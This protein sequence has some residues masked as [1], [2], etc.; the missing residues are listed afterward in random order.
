MC[1]NVDSLCPVC[2]HRVAGLQVLYPG[3]MSCLPC[4]DNAFYAPFTPWFVS[5]RPERS[6]SVTTAISKVKSVIT[7]RKSLYPWPF[8][9]IWRDV[10]GSGRGCIDGGVGDA[11]WLRTRANR[12]TPTIPISFK[13]TRP[14]P[15]RNLL[16]TD[17]SKKSHCICRCQDEGGVEGRRHGEGR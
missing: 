11:L 6:E 7:Y 9:C 12:Y 2:W 1:L 4:T 10:R 5:H 17:R 8:R 14:N 15:L 13:W 3:H 16:K